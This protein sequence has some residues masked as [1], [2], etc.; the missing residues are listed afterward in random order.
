MYVKIAEEHIRRCAKCRQTCLKIP[1]PI[2]GEYLDENEESGLCQ[3]CFEDHVAAIPDEWFDEVARK[4]QSEPG[5]QQLAIPGFL[6]E[7]RN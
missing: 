4:T 7:Q 2:L 1:D 3:D 5:G 6:D